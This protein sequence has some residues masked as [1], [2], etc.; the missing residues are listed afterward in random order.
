[1]IGIGFQFH[2][3]T[4]RTVGQGAKRP[5]DHYFN[6]IKVRLE[7]Q[8]DRLRNRENQNFNSI[9][10]RLEH[11]SRTMPYNKKANFNSIKVR[12][13]LFTLYEP[14]SFMVISIP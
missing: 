6:S 7:P 11:S 2:K 3:G 14:R 8:D 12:L 1:M 10:V 4:I 5:P 13:E 9:K